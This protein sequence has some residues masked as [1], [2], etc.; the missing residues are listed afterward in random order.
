MPVDPVKTNCISTAH[1]VGHIIQG[2][3]SCEQPTQVV[4]ID[5]KYSH[6]FL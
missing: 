4:T 2:H 1:D 3:H 5:Q 6:F